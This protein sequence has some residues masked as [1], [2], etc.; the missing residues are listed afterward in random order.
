VIHRDI[1][2]ANILLD[3]DTG[4]AVL[5]DFGIAKIEGTGDEL[6]ATGMIIGT[7]SYMSPEQAAGDAPV[8]ARTDVYS[9]GGVGYAML[10][11]REPVP[12]EP[13]PSTVPQE[14]GRILMRALAR[15]PESRWP[16]AK[17]M[18]D[19]L[20][21]AARDD[22]VPESLRDLPS[23]GPYALL[24]ALGW[25]I[26]AAQ[27]R[28]PADGALLFLVAL[29]VPIGFVLHLWNL[30]RHGAHAG[31][32]ARVAFWPPEWWGMW[33]PAPLRRPNDVWTRLP[34]PARVI[35]VVMSVFCIALPAMVLT[36]SS[37]ASQEMLIA[38]T[39]VILAAALLWTR[40]R[41][42]EWGDAVRVLFGATSSSPAWSDPAVA[43]MLSSPGGVRLPDPGS[44]TD[45]HRAIGELARA[46][47]DEAAALRTEAP[48]L[49]ARL[50]A[51]IDDCNRELATLSRD[52]SATELDRLAAQLSALESEPHRGAERDELLALVR[53]QLELVHD[54]R[55]RAELVAQRRARLFGF[56][57]GL[58]TQLG[59]VRAGNADAMQLDRIRQDI[60]AEL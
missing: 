54:M 27:R 3:Q 42:L 49:S 17:A 7:P 40:R 41:R 50:L 52:A 6:T 30:G 4:H 39:A 1:K 47:P 11:G 48:L 20:T 10:T 59:A 46:L 22:A 55:V 51:A 60:G 34:W 2:P 19:A 12:L 53:R 28:G 31:D 32:L 38:S 36:R 57:R 29:L 35:R 45:H 9:L 56:L 58:W 23:F 13:L 33:W 43:R 5:A 8:D 44:A 21:R 16:S 18:R 14:L 37:L 26:L 24:W 15:D 25:M